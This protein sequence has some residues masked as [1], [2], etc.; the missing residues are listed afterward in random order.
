MEFHIQHPYYH[1]WFHSDCPVTWSLRT[2]GVLFWTWILYNDNSSKCDEAIGC[3]CDLNF[4]HMNV[5]LAV[6]GTM[7]TQK[8]LHNPCP[9]WQILKLVIH[10]SWWM[11]DF[12]Y[13]LHHA[14]YL[15][16]QIL[17]HYT[18]IHNHHLH[19]PSPPNSPRNKL[20]SWVFKSLCSEQINLCI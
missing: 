3:P 16:Q 8:L 15:L 14:A 19:V 9:S 7:I 6:T 1:Q 12:S 2:V 11:T 20:S 5:C 18:Y 17:N 10:Q 13:C 4:S